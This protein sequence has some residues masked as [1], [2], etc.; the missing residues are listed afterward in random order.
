MK[1]VRRE[2][3]QRVKEVNLYF[4]FLENMLDSNVCLYFNNRKSWKKRPVNTEYKKY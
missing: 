2:F 4:D 1:E 3:K